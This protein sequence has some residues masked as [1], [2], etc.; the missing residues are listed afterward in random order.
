[1][2]RPKRWDAPFDPRMSAEMVDQLMRIEPFS[3]MDEQAFSRNLPLRGILQNDCRVVHHMPGDI[4]IREGDYGNSAF[5]ILDGN[6]CVSL[7]P[8]PADILG[9]SEPRKKSTWQALQQLWKNRRQAEVRDYVNHDAEST[10]PIGQRHDDS[11]EPQIF[12]QDL[13]RVLQPGQTAR[14][15]R[16]EMFGEL[17]AL[18]RTPRSATVVAE[19]E[20]QLLEIRWQGLRDLLKRD[21]AM[22]QHIDQL[23]RQNS[24]QVHLRATPL[25][26]NLS[27]SEIADIASV[28]EFQ[29]FGNL[30]WQHQF[31]NLDRRDVAERILAE[32]VMVQQG[33][34]VNGLLLVRNGF[35]R[36]S[37]VHGDG[38][39][40]I[41]YLGKGD[42][43][44][45]RELLHNWQHHE[46]RPYLL[47]LRSVGYVD[48][49][50]IPTHMVESRILP[51]LD[52]DQLPPPLSETSVS[53]AR[54][55]ARPAAERRQARRDQQVDSG[56]LEFLVENRFINGTQAMMIDLNR[57]TRCDDCVRACSTAHDN[58]PRFIRQGLKHEQWLITN[59]CMHCADPVCMI[60]CPTGAIGRDENSGVV[61]I[62]DQTC[63]GCATCANS[64]PYDNIQMVQIRDAEGN[65]VVDESRQ[66]P[67]EK[68]TKCD[69]CIDQLGGPACQ[70]A[71]PHDALVRID[72]TGTQQLNQ[73]LHG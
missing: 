73:L 46:Q 36:V 54:G 15:Q 40:T 72:L 9:R 50:R 49:L 8:L 29:S 5:Q 52:E 21:P 60:G 42:V 34:Y 70:R 1:M 45:L 27:D 59:A 23:Y 6:L 31:Q 65:A 33:E 43:F 14:L 48:V 51:R 22:R 57:C 56:L 7:V 17:A 39:Q 20:C 19:T 18:N 30:E 26:R 58:N 4:V 28:T 68:A 25:L 67:I 47:G 69:L 66:Q 63:I 11:G 10:A 3:R 62:N 41:A 24:L 2:A 16:G 64:C 61:V 12:I 35:A 71:C 53:G 37:R 38:F 44:G 32:P 55:E 13:P